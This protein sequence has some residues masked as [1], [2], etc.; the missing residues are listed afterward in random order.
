MGPLRKPV[1]RS[2]FDET[3]DVDMSAGI[4]ADEP[5][6]AEQ[7][8]ESIEGAAPDAKIRRGDGDEGDGIESAVRSGVEAEGEL[9]EEEDD[10]PD[11]ESDEALPDDEEEHAIRRDMAG[12]GVRY[13]PE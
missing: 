3:E 10:N 7:D 1:D 9:P 8:W 4:E 5:E 12:R 11:Q 2:R 13:E 6:A